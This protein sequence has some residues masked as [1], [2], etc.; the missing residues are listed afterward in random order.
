M[1][2]RSSMISYL[3]NAYSEEIDAFYSGGQICG[4]LVSQGPITP[5]TTPP[6]CIIV[7]FTR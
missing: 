6:G 4:F 1:E 2:T 5:P 3:G 7:S